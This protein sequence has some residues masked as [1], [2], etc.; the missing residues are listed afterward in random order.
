M[1]TLARLHDWRLGGHA[2]RWRARRRAGQAAPADQPPHR[3][4]THRSRHRDRCWPL[5]LARTG[6]LAA[7]RGRD[8]PTDAGTGQVEGHE[9]PEDSTGAPTQRWAGDSRLW[10]TRSPATSPTP[11]SASSVRCS[12]ST[13]AFER[14]LHGKR[15][16]TSRGRTDT[17][18][19]TPDA[20]H[21][22]ARRAHADAAHPPTL[23]PRTAVAAARPGE[24]IRPSNTSS[25]I[26]MRSTNWPP[27]CIRPFAA[28]FA[29]SC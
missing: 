28:D 5:A 25:T 3:R 19:H 27:V 12:A 16:R 18:G 15:R 11:S 2:S 13:R 23:M 22:S 14:G 6:R 9:T 17:G 20:A 29:R 24:H 7:S 21:A 4:A 8:R 10:A 26:R 1:T